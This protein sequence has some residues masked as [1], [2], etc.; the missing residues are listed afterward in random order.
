MMTDIK[1]NYSFWL[2]EKKIIF[3]AASQAHLGVPV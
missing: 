3:S 1:Q 2:L